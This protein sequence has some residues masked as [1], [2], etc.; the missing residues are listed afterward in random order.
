MD[1]NQL[2]LETPIAS[3]I[4]RPQ[5]QPAGHAPM[6]PPRLS[7]EPQQRKEISFGWV[8][9]GVVLL[10]VVGFC[11]FVLIKMGSPAAPVE[12]VVEL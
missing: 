3:P 7:R 11:G 1:D 12:T 4:S 2:P 10:A 8:I 9:L 5:G 6:L